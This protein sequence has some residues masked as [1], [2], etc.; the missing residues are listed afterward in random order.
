ML[1]SIHPQRGSL[2]PDC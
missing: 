2:V 1:G